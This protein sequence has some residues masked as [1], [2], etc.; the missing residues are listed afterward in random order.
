MDKKVHHEKLFEEAF[1]LIIRLHSEPE[2]PAGRQ[3]AARWCARGP[4]YQAVWDE[5]MQLHK[6]SGQ[7]K[8]SARVHRA[9]RFSR[10]HFL[11]GIAAAAAAVAVAPELLLPLQSDYQTRTG[12][13]RSLQLSGGS[14]IVLGPDSAISEQ[15][16]G[17]EKQVNLLKGMAFFNIKADQQQPF[18]IH[19]AGL[20]MTTLAAAFELSNDADICQIAVQQGSLHVSSPQA[21]YTLIAGQ[22]LTFPEN[23]LPVLGHRETSQIAA[24]RDNSLIADNEYVS[25]V[26]ARLARWLPGS[27]MI[28]SRHL[29]KQRISGAFNLAHP[30]QALSA[31][32]APFQAEIRHITPWLTLLSDK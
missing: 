24:W 7:L 11:T 12:Q 16:D 1:E 19:Q 10:R 26:V 29:Q 6:L 27:V 4:E 8:S 21:A 25:A 2:N 20:H 30:R 5:A 22:S 13:L 3:Q 18:V 15:F 17:E 32:A 9:H 23:E 28:T 31:V 14:Q